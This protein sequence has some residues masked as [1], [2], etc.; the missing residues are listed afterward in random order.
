MQWGKIFANYISDSRL[1]YKIKKE[2]IQLNSKTPTN[3][4]I[5]KCPKD[6]NRRFS[7]GDIQMAK[8][9]VKM[10]VIIRVKKLKTFIC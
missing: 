5:L 10:C 7:K 1:T 2:C 4:P 9:Y 8:R 3:N 6:L